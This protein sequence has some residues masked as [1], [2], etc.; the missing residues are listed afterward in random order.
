MVLKVNFTDEEYERLEVL[1]GD[2]NMAF[3]DVI[4]YLIF[5]QFFFLKADQ[6]RKASQIEVNE[7]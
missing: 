7:T 5:K 4:N 3:D 1:C 2:F 6:E